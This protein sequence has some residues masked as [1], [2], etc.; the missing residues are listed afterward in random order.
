MISCAQGKFDD[1]LKFAKEHL[2]GVGRKYGQDSVENTNARAL[3]AWS[4][5]N[6]GQH[7][8][9]I[10]L[11]QDILAWRISNLGTLDTSVGVTKMRLA[12]AYHSIGRDMEARSLAEEA[13][14]ILAE[15]LKPGDPILKETLALVQK[16]GGTMFSATPIEADRHLVP[17]AGPAITQDEMLA[18]DPDD[19]ANPLQ[20]VALPPPY[21]FNTPFEQRRAFG[22][23]PGNPWSMFY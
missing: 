22:R 3:V 7:C 21:R 13:S 14:A 5:S 16:V 17:L 4:M 19:E 8:E 11:F 6:H 2:H 18:P 1:M 15:K 20:G 9:A 23:Q 12:E 10:D